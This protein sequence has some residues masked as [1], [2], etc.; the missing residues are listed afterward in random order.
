[1]SWL[2]LVAFAVLIPLLAVAVW[3][4]PLRGLYVLGAGLLV[5]NT[6]FVL[7]H[8]FGAGG[9][10]VT[11]AQSWKECVLLVALARVGRDALR[12]G[13][14]GFTARPADVVAALFAIVVMAYLAIPQDVLG[15]TASFTAELY[16]ARHFLLPLGAYAVGRS[17]DVSKSE[18]ATAASF[19]FFLGPLAA[20][21]GMTEEYLVPV[22]TWVGIDAPGYFHGQLGFPEGYGPGGLPENFVFNTSDGVYR[23]LV[24]F[25]LSPLGSAYMFVVLLCLA[26]NG[27]VSRIRPALLVVGAALSFTGL[28]FTFTRSAVLAFAGAI[29]ICGVVIG[30][31]KP[32]LTGALAIVVA[33]A[34]AAVFPTIAPR[35]H[36]LAEDLPRQEALSRETGQPLGA[37]PLQSTLQFADPSSRSH[38]TELA[39]GMQSLASHPQGFGLG[40]SGQTALRFAIPL[41]A[42]ESFY[43]ELGADIGIAGLCLWSIFSLLVLGGLIAAARSAEAAPVRRLAAGVFAAMAALMAVA[44]VSDVWGSPW[45]TYVV[46]WLAGAVLNVRP[47]PSGPSHQATRVP[48]GRATDG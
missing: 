27:A 33:I 23:R 12:I 30:R 20:V 21:A 41:R 22:E 3:Q 17:L 31:W 44:L 42:G 1:V 8:S 13:R 19:L 28:L 34:F 29:V 46:W 38:L 4:R 6:L 2:V 9:W 47:G 39:T 18:L 15:G 48:A 45:P 10:Q 25:F 5:H 24:S 36:F 35:T 14:P 11:V 26:M 7:L 40:N 37:D 32:A 16:A 43:L